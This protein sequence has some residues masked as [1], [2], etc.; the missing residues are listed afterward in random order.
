MSGK[1]RAF[2]RR[3]VQLAPVQKG[4][5][6]EPSQPFSAFVDQTNIVLLGDPGAGKTH[7]FRCAAEA[8]GGLF[9]RARDFLNIPTIPP[10]PALFI[11]ALDEKR[12]GRGD[13]DAVDQ[14]IR[15][16]FQNPPEKVRI[17]CR[18]SDWIGESD[19]VAFKPSFYTQGGVMVLS[20]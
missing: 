13:D 4:E 2:D 19:L 9:L 6:P 12:S 7:L 11:D 10:R 8:V 18:I 3:V 1:T 20:L 5:N 14:I 16:L 17:S 15:K